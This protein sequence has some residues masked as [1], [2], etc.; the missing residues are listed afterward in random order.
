LNEVFQGVTYKNISAGSVTGQYKVNYSMVLVELADGKRVIVHSEKEKTFFVFNEDL[1]ELCSFGDSQKME[2]FVRFQGNLVFIQGGSK[3]WGVYKYEETEEAETISGEIRLV[4]YIDN[5]SKV[6]GLVPGE[7]DHEFFLFY[8]DKQVYVGKFENSTVK[9]LSA[10]KVPNPVAYPR[11]SWNAALNYVLVNERLLCCLEGKKLKI[12]REFEKYAPDALLISTGI[13]YFTGEICLRSY[14]GEELL[15]IGLASDHEL[16]GKHPGKEYKKSDISSIVNCQVFLGECADKLID[17][18]VWSVDCFA[19]E[20]EEDDEYAD[21][22][23]CCRHIKVK[24][25]EK[26]LEEEKI[27]E[28]KKSGDEQKKEKDDKGDDKGGKGPGGSNGQG[29]GKSKG[30]EGDKGNKDGKGKDKGG[31][32]HSGSKAKEKGDNERDLDENAIQEEGERIV[33]EENLLGDIENQLEKRMREFCFLGRN[34]MLEERNSAKSSWQPLKRL[35]C[36]D[37]IDVEN[38]RAT[39]IS[40]DSQRVKFSS[41]FFIF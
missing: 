33:C 4:C 37:Q 24:P 5:S 11:L 23:G 40:K 2:S 8:D 32:N 26:V 27:I 16:L 36:K 12:V 38:T 3:A 25:K 18:C 14:E 35:D 17:L 31:D 6:K 9:V 15:K 28:E 1:E 10:F 21:F 39:L 34:F 19:Y 20:K 7:T 22:V 13:V 30:D 29:D 41:N